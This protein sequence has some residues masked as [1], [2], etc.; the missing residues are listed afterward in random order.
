MIFVKKRR[1]S[2]GSFS[3]KT[4]K[5]PKLFQEY[6]QGAGAVDVHNHIRQGRIRLEQVWKTH[7]WENRMTASLIGIV[8]TNAFLAFNYFRENPSEMDHVKFRELLSSALLKDN[9]GDNAN[10]GSALAQTQNV[11]AQNQGSD[12]AGPHL[13]KSFGNGKQMK[14]IVCSRIRQLQIKASHYCEK[15][16]IRTAL[17]SPPLI[18]TV[19]NTI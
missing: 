7:S 8:E 9:D 1:G 11:L 12:N 19:L 6:Q 16:G 5:R 2:D 10:E 4:V 17:C 15:C 13:L 18:V 3:I 14:C